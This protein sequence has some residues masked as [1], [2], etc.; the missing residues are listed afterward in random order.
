MASKRERVEQLLDFVS[1]CVSTHGFTA[2][3][4]FIRHNTMRR[5]T[6]LFNLQSDIVALGRCAG[7]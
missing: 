5:V 4:Y 3:N 7:A 1:F 6:H 2:R